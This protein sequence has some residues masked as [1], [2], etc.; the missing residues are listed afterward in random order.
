VLQYGATQ[1][2]NGSG[3]IHMGN[4]GLLIGIRIVRLGTGR[5]GKPGRYQHTWRRWKRGW[6]GPSNGV[7]LLGTSGC[8][9]FGGSART[10]RFGFA[11]HRSG[12]V[13]WL[14]VVG[15]NCLFSVGPALDNC[16]AVAVELWSTLNKR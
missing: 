10:D 16:M 1:I 5:S 12:Y 3:D 11:C 2:W 15:P 4:S 7:Q 8:R 13:C 14:L 9:T 6:C